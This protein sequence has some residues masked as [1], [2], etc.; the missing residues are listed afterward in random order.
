MPDLS[1]LSGDELHSAG[2]ACQFL[3]ELH[4][5]RDA[6]DHE[7]YIKLDTLLADIQAMQEDRQQAERRA[8]VAAAAARYGIPG[9]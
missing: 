9:Q 8:R 6:L 2:R 7:L 3:L 1:L 5:T 4:R